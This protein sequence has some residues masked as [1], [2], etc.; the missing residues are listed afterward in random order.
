MPLVIVGVLAVWLPESIEFLTLRE[1]PRAR[2]HLLRPVGKL[3]SDRVI[4]PDAVFI[5]P[6]SRQQIG[7]PVAELFRNGLHWITP[8]LWLQ[9]VSI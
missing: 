8:L 3:C 4:P 1:G 9:F 7:V 5:T 6:E 2:A